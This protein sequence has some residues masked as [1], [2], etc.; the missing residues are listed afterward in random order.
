MFDSVRYRDQRISLSTEVSLMK[1]GFSDFPKRFLVYAYRLLF[2]DS[3]IYK[4][5]G[6]TIFITVVG[7]VLAMLV[8]SAL[9]YPL[10]LRSVKIS[11]SCQFLCLLYLAV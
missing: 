2:K 7:T 4:A 10:S 5:Y 1:Y 3:T 11:Q 8:T 6:V 9:A